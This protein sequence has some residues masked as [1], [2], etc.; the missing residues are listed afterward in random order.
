MTLREKIILAHPRGFC[1][2]VKNAIETV[3]RLLRKQQR[4]IYVRH[5]IVHNRHV[6]GELRR[7][8]VVFVE[9]LDEIPDGADVVFSAHGVPESVEREARRRNLVISD[10]TCPIVKKIHGLARKYSEAGL[11]LILIGNRRHP[12]IIGTSGRI[13]GPFHIVEEAADAGKICPGASEHFACLTQTTL[14]P[15]ETASTYR[16]LKRRLGAKLTPFKDNICYA[17]R[18]RQAAVRKLAGR[19]DVFFIIGSKNSSNSKRLKELAGKSGARAFLIDDE[20]SIRKSMLRSASTIG[21]SSGASA[22]E[23]LVSAVV[24][25]LSKWGWTRP[26]DKAALP[27]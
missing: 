23:R 21:I 25:K 22:P 18:E 2:G 16:A 19:V 26:K 24:E 14:N 17:T 10:A 8:G 1:A 11:T 12:E 6:I 9:S 4:P 13:K 5:E 7:K 15:E 27:N 3:E 20:K